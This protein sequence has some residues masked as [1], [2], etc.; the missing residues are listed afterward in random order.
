MLA[1]DVALLV[2]LHEEATTN[3]QRQKDSENIHLER[4]LSMYG[5]L[6]SGTLGSR[7]VP[8]W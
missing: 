7:Q 6:E 3:A 5:M 2:Q 4:F 8:F 1:Y